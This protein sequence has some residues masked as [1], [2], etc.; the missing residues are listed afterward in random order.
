[1]SQFIQQLEGWAD[2]YK[3]N[4]ELRVLGGPVI[5]VSEPSDMERMVL[6]RPSRFRRGLTPVSVVVMRNSAALEPDVKRSSHPLC[7][8]IVMSA[9]VA[10]RGGE[11]PV[12]LNKADFAAT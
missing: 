11:H 3:G 5:I 1:M 10:L 7:T 4:Y 8:L 6:L 12:V 9:G 2:K